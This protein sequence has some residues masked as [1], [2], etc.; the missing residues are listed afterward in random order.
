[1]HAEQAIGAARGTR[2][3]VMFTIGTGIGG[4]VIADGA[5]LRGRA[6]AG[7]LGHITVDRGGKACLCGRHGCVETTSS[8]TALGRHLAEAGL[9][10]GTSVE[11]LL[12]RASDGD[13][14]A[15]G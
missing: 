11:T 8:G 13:A 9:P 14:T 4:A 7:Q 5:L 15:K 6:S 3:V 1:T 2:S 12:A 10:T